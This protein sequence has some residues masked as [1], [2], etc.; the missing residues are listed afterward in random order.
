MDYLDGTALKSSRAE[1]GKAWNQKFNDRNRKEFDRPFLKCLRGVRME[2]ELLDAF[3]QNT[4]SSTLSRE[5]QR[6]K[7]ILDSIL[8]QDNTLAWVESRAKTS[9]SNQV[10]PKNLTPDGL[11]GF[12]KNRSMNAVSDADVVRHLIF[13]RQLDLDFAYALAANSS[14]NEVMALR[15]AIRRHLMR[16]TA[17]NVH[18]PHTGFETFRLELSL[19][20][21]ILEERDRLQSS[22]AEVGCGIERLETDLSFLNIGADQGDGPT[23]FSIW[24]AHET[25]LVFGCDVFEWTGYA[26]SARCPSM[27]EGQELT[28]G[29]EAEEDN[30]SMPEED[31]FATGDT[32]YD[33][34]LVLDASS[35]KLDPR[36]Y[37]LCVLAIRVKIIGQRYDS[38]IRTLELGVDDWTKS[39]YTA[40]SPRPAPNVTINTSQLGEE[41]NQIQEVLHALRTHLSRTIAVWVRFSGAGGDISFFSDVNDQKAKFALRDTSEEFA[42]LE[43]QLQKLDGVDR[44]L[45]D[46]AKAL[47]RALNAENYQLARQT[48]GLNQ[49]INI[50]AI[51]SQKS[52]AETN[53][54]TKANVQV[55]AKSLQSNHYY[56]Q[57]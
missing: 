49:E 10:L 57:S 34:H 13:I 40:K 47:K 22:T 30:G 50:I 38:L 25:V 19:P 53:R 2:R 14:Y 4:D 45:E 29:I 39:I 8:R 11:A 42:D 48:L 55:S 32:N 41:I 24:K 23:R 5:V 35:P 56:L 26:F 20:Y 16:E 52:V 3:L 37:F 51:D 36:V 21:L 18:V 43:F 9:D 46:A 7:R 44:T 31:M 12:I 6:V 28:P 27:N 1:Y 15:P 33:D 17:I 54:T